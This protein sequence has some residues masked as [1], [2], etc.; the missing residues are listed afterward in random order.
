MFKLIL[1]VCMH[2]HRVGMVLC[3]SYMWAMLSDSLW[4]VP[5]FSFKL[6]FPR[7]NLTASHSFILQADF[8]F[9]LFVHMHVCVCAQV[10]TC[11]HA[12]GGTRAN[13]GTHCSSLSPRLWRLC[14]RHVSVVF[15]ACFNTESWRINLLVACVTTSSFRLECWQL[16]E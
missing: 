5:V 16:C 10:N 4:K 11:E 1:I 6:Y 15:L 9:L 2:A 13:L 8:L 14:G 3:D 12:C 7:R